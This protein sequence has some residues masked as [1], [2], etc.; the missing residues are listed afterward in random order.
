MTSA[1]DT[2]RFADVSDEN[3]AAV[4][5]HVDAARIV[6]QML[7]DLRAHPDQW[8][9]STLERFLDALAA[10]LDAV[11][12][13]HTNRGGPVASQPTWR[14]LAELLVKASGYE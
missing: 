3:L 11:E 10:S 7:A 8:E 13:L 14:L 5:S 4:R 1:Y 2:G 9:N 12:P 6:E